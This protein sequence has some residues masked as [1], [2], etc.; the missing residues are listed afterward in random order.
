MPAAGTLVYESVS[1]GVKSGG[2]TAHN[3]V[4]APAVDPFKPEKLTAY[5]VGIKSDI[6]P[7]LRIETAAFY[8]RYRRSADSGQGL[9][10]ERSESYIGEFV[11]ANSRISGGE[12]QLEWRPVAG[13]VH[14]PVLRLRRRLLHEHSA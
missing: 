13:P 6:T 9:R 2:F 8:Y 5:E 10:R 12:G 4:S 11:N 1:R 14:L 7:T 3:T